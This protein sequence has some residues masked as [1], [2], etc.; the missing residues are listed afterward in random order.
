MF[1][2]RGVHE[3]GQPELME[4]EF[5]LPVR[6]RL[7]RRHVILAAAG[8]LTIAIFVMR[9]ISGDLADGLSFL[10]VVPV[11]L[12]SLELGLSAGIVSALFAFVLVI[13]WSE[14]RTVPLDGGELA[15]R[16][17]ALVATAAICGR[18]ADRMRGARTRQQ[19]LLAS[20]LALG[21]STDPRE[22]PEL[23][24]RVATT[25]VP[26]RGARITIESL[27]PV[28]TGSLEGELFRLIVRA[29]EADCGLLEISPP[30]GRRFS[31]DEQI[32]L[33]LLAVQVAVATE[34]HRITAL[35][36]DRARLH[37]ELSEA[38]GQLAEQERRLELLLSTQ[39]L[40]R[41]SIAHEL[42]DQAAQTLAAI[43]LGMSA[44]ERDLSS[45]P[46][47]AQVETLRS[48]L[49]DTLRTL[50]E[51]AVDLRPPAL[52]QLG[53]E[54]ALLGLAERALARSGHVVVV[55]GLGERLAPHLETTVYRVVDDLVGA[56]SEPARL[57][58]DVLRAGSEL[59]IVAAAVDG[60][61][62]EFPSALLAERIEARLELVG[63]FLA[64]GRP[65]EG[66]IVAELAIVDPYAE[67]A[68]ET[69]VPGAAAA[70]ASSSASR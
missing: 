55:H 39:E 16:L 26:A 4:R 27:P 18:Y 32:A 9:Q 59:R 40:E 12:V 33:E 1:L 23:V 50:R 14:S 11:A 31:R 42:H 51:L 10:Y 43:Q 60:T 37:A 69:D 6:G 36:L 7:E 57:H 22:L 15:V 24:A 63:G 34:H 2:L 21:E 46:T 13:V 29:G 44:V 68:L 56:L 70:S 17:A 25:L 45:E 49:G 19:Q 64:R 58:V 20:G 28:T 52:D 48:H 53:L 8:L 35:Q 5:S 38:H 54:P 66:R 41:Q 62:G 3:R 65:S 67:G 61:G 30:L 47:R